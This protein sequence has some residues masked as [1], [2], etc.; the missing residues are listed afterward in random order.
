MKR[1]DIKNKLREN[2]EKNS[3]GV[4]VT[5]SDKILIVMRGISG[6]GKSTKAKS[7]VNEGVIH[8]T[9][10]LIESSGN[11]REFFASMIES[12]NFSNLSRMH[13][14]NLLNAKK[15]MD[16][17]I[18]PIIIDNTNLRANETKA[19]VTYALESG[20]AD[21]NIQIVD[22]GTG[23]LTAN[24]L[25]ERNSHGVPLEKIEQMVKTHKSVGPLT[26]KKIIESKDMYKE[27]NVLY[28]AVVLDEKSKS[29]LLN[30]FA[31]EIPT[32]WK[33]IAHHMTI[34][35]GKAVK[36]TEDLDKEVTLTVLELGVSD[37][38][39]AV[40]VSGYE[41]NNAIPH[42]TLAVNPNGGKPVMSNQI[43]NWV[44]IENFTI[45]GV[46]KNILK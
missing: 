6:S 30:H 43:T 34:A 46:V 23:G 5:K 42:I 7:L 9:D 25:A 41:S 22:I 16:A 21:E 44:P 37:M 32:D 13:S 15:S 27:S 45:K 11:Y 19:Y 10:D 12:K 14:K 26:L 29:I 33:T 35:F 20:Y 2:L 38:A 24:Q 3:L 1:N 18:T 40:K 31:S 36:N 4:L 28:S 17:G 39:I 8:S